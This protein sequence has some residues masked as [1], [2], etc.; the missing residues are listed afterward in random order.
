MF[1]SILIHLENGLNEIYFYFT[2]SNGNISPGAVT[3]GNLINLATHNSRRDKRKKHIW[4]ESEGNTKIKLIKTSI[5]F[6]F[7]KIGSGGFVKRTIKK[8]WPNWDK[9]HVTKSPVWCIVDLCPL[10]L[11]RCHTA[12]HRH[13]THYRFEIKQNSVKSTVRSEIDHFRCKI[14]SGW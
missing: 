7:Q 6:N 11:D 1:P 10:E 3:G 4:H 13:N 9:I 5:F 12:V 8:L 14:G 2:N